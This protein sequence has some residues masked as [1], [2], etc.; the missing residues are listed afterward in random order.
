MWGCRRNARPVGYVVSLVPPAGRL[1]TR[2]GFIRHAQLGDLVFFERK[3]ASPPIP[4]GAHVT[5]TAVPNMT[6]P[7]QVALESAHTARRGR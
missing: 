7:G 3:L 6:R 1:G 5:F 4:V 2:T